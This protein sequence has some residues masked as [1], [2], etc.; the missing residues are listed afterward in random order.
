MIDD[1][2]G[3]SRLAPRSTS[4]GSIR[5]VVIEDDPN[6]LNAAIR[7]IDADDD[8]VC[9]GSAVDLTS[10]L[11]LL[12]LTPA[13]VMVV[14][15]GLPD[16]SGVDLIQ[17]ARIA[18]SDCDIMVATVFGD[19]A[20]IIAAIEAGAAGYILKDSEPAALTAEIR[21]LHAGGS[22]ISPLIARRLL[23]RFSGVAVVA[24]TPD[25][26]S[27]LSAREESVLSLITKGFS[28]SEVA[29]KLGVSSHTVRT[30]VRR[31]YIKLGVNTKAEAIQAARGDGRF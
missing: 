12:D 20:H 6:F 26:L 7:S 17:A 16:G 30:F 13:D 11:G 25:A 21:S 8:M 1:M 4:N 23:S 31:I 15:L 22:P 27:S 28:Q 5:V 18:W 9:I 14:D 29:A 24:D 3:W 19:E 10:G 2:K